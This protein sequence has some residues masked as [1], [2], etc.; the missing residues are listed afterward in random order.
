MRAMQAWRRVIDI[1]GL[2][3]AFL[4]LNA[5]RGTFREGFYG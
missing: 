1:E 3:S 4:I 2:G 5:K